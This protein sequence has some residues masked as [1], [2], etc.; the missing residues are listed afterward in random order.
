MSESIGSGFYFVGIGGIGMSALAKAAL[1]KGLDVEGS[2]VKRTVTTEFLQQL[3]AR[4]HF[5]QGTAVIPKNMTV[6]VSSATEDNPQVKRAQR[7]GHRVLHRSDFLSDMMQG[8]KNLLVA[9][10]HGKTTTSCLLVS[11]LKEAGL[12]PSFCVGGIHSDLKTNGAFGKGPYFVAEADESDGTHLKYKGYGAI[13]TNID[14]D[15]IDHY[16]HLEKI[17]ESFRA[18]FDNIEM[19]EHLFWNGDDP[20]L[21]KLKPKGRSFGF[22][23]ASDLRASRFR[24]K[25]KTA[26]FDVTFEGKKYSD[27]ELSLIG[28][29]QVLNAL[30][31]FGVAISLG[32]S[33]EVIR[34]A[35]TLFSGV[36]RR[37]QKH[38]DSKG[39]LFYDDYAHHPT[40]VKSTLESLRLAFPEKRLVVALQP[41]RYTRLKGLIEEFS[42]AFDAA[43]KVFIAEV[44][45][46]GEQPI[47]DVSH[48][49][50]VERIERRAPGLA[51]AI[52]KEKLITHLIDI[53]RPHDLL[54]TMGAGDLLDILGPLKGHF[55]KYGAKKLKVALIS[56]GASLEHE[57]SKWSAINIEKV[58]NPDYYDVDT[59][60]ISKKGQWSG[61]LG[62]LPSLEV[63]R[64]YDIAFPMIHGAEG[65]DG[66]L[67]GFLQEMRLPYVGSGILGS[68]LSMDKETARAVVASYG[69]DTVKQYPLYR[70]EWLEDPDSLIERI[71]EKCTCPFVIKPV[72]GG[73]T[74]GVTLI[75]SEEEL[76]L[77]LEKLFTIDTKLVA[78]P[79]IEARELEFALVGTGSHVE[80]LFPGEVFAKG[81]LYDFKSKYGQGGGIET[82]AR[83]QLS[84]EFARK[85]KLIAC[86]I[87]RALNLSGFARLDFFYDEKSG[88]LIFNEA[89]VIPGFT[90]WSLYPKL[91]EKNGIRVEDFVSRM[92][93]IG[94]LDSRTRLR[95][96]ANQTA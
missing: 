64:K 45:A 66:Q 19:K 6:V 15:H 72:S 42:L 2:D 86:G 54:V 85:S 10:M 51:S 90:D 65:E 73:S 22:S 20:I 61:N 13:V 56:G 37:L 47:W 29:H 83:A 41:H 16:K 1:E 23:K 71:L 78:E 95:I 14:L 25:E 49:D 5:D 91:L 3:G 74:Y 92:I 18:F 21:Q 32:V 89:N 46:A 53:L 38:F 70:F 33:E 4:V 67:Q 7:L 63:L 79:F 52:S 30:G 31:V 84:A 75:E 24:Q 17:E 62:L 88:A 94:L 80:A 50:L 27:I 48:T 44:F 26:I 96:N 40:A 81:R 87:F 11:V 8:L 35:F 60:Y 9:G 77:G 57:V 34:R 36:H 43:D 28:R 12:D 93:A 82:S 55:Q 59:L 68:A 39:L 58:L 69:F 76:A